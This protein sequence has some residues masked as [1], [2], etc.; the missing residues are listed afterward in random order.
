[1]S[2]KGYTEWLVNSLILINVRVTIILSK[3]TVM[4]ICSTYQSSVGLYSFFK[5]DRLALGVGHYSANYLASYI[6]G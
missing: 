5:Y 3:L 2:P 4:T 1:M 6:N